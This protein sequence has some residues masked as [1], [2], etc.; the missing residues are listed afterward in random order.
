MGPVF[1]P[2]TIGSH[3]IKICKT[4][5]DLHS[6]V[7]LYH[8][9]IMFVYVCIIIKISFSQNKLKSVGLIE[10]HFNHSNDDF[11]FE[12][13]GWQSRGERPSWEACK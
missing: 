13:Q 2:M 7:M 1:E 4:V 3:D 5:M 11:C 12:G 8:T 9:S 10:L 6:N